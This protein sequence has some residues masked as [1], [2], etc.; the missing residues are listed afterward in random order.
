[1]PAVLSAANEIAVAAFVGG[2]IRFGQIPAVIEKTMNGAPAEELS[3]DGV[4]RAD[5]SARDRARE[6]VAQLRRPQAQE[7]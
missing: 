1:M 6:V 5:R 3:L 2:E 4:R 7:V